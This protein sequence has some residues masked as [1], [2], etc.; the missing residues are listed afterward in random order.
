MILSP[1]EFSDL[2]AP[3]ITE[4][5]GERHCDLAV[6]AEVLQ[7]RI[8]KLKEIP[9]MLGFALRRG[10]MDSELFTHKKSKL[11]P[12]VCLRVLERCY[13]DLFKK[14]IAA[15]TASF[16]REKLHEY[17]M[18][19]GAELELKT[20]QVMG[21]IRLACAR[22]QV[23]PGGATELLLIL[24]RHEAQARIEEAIAYLKSI[25]GANNE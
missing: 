18:S 15:T 5:F 6:L 1:A 12:S 21:P 14:N 4:L 3:T 2:I 24:G 23:T 19:L 17:L 20:G 9:E 10:E 13:E 25:E 16:E 22:Q 11:N 7:T 8:C